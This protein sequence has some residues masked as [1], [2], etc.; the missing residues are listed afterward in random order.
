MAKV[1]IEFY[2]HLETDE[3]PRTWKVGD[4]VPAGSDLER[5]AMRE[6]WCKKK[7]APRNKSLTSAPANKSASS[8]A[9]HR[10]RKKTP[11]R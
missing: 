3:Q 8:R 5:V 11:K 1:I 9:G 6:G 10:P 7:P 2:G 4:V